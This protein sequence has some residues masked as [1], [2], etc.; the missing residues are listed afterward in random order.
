MN[1][2]VINFANCNCGY[3]TEDAFHYFFQCP[4]YR[5]ER[6]NMTSA[7]A[8]IT[9]PSLATILYGNDN[10]SLTSNQGVFHAVHDFIISTKRFEQ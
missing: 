5:V 2:H 4:L 3:H 9:D 6:Q 10:L 7:I 8:I 1:L